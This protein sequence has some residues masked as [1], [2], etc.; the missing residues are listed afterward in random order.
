MVFFLKKAIDFLGRVAQTPVVSRNSE[1]HSLSWNFSTLLFLN[2][3]RS[4]MMNV[5]TS[6][7]H[8]CLVRDHKD[9]IVSATGIRCPDASSLKE[10]P[11]KFAIWINETAD[12][13]FLANEMLTVSM[14]TSVTAISFS[15]LYL[16]LIVSPSDGDYGPNPVGSF[17]IFD[18]EEADVFLPRQTFCYWTLSSSD[19][20]LM[21]LTRV[22]FVSLSVSSCWNLKFTRNS[23]Y[24]FI[25]GSIFH[26]LR[27]CLN[28]HSEHFNQTHLLGTWR[29]RS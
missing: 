13:I 19:W 3:F 11:K 20:V 26:V 16:L 14:V 25:L 15:I 27:C 6:F 29:Y 4:A 17:L 8:V 22:S 1:Y 7:D 23:M 18:A 21:S 28:L 10:L 2:R 9:K 5:E 12:S 24:L